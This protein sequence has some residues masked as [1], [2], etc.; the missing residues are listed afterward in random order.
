MKETSFNLKILGLTLISF[1]LKT[2]KASDKETL[3]LSNSNREIGTYKPEP[4]IQSN[5]GNGSIRPDLKELE[6]KVLN[7]EEI[8]KP[9]KVKCT[10]CTG[11]T[12]DDD[13]DFCMKCGKVICSN[14]GSIDTDGKKYCTECWTSL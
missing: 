8:P 13:L 2:E 6:K 10:T 1:N 5:I 11:T 9:V 7:K 14:C 4:I 3:E 12:Y